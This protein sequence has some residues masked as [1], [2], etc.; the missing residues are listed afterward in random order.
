M[1]RKLFGILLSLCMILSL[2][3]VSAFAAGTGF[4][5]MPAEGTWS[6]EAIASAVQ[7]GLLQGD[8]GKLTPEGSLTR[9]QLAAIINR[10]FGAEEEADISGYTDVTASSWYYADIAKAVGMGTLQGYGGSMRP[11]DPVTRQEAFAVLARAFKLA[12]GSASSL[13]KFADSDQVADWAVPSLSAMVSAGYVQGSDGKLN[14][15]SS[16]SRAE[17]A[18][19]VY[20][21]ISVYLTSAAFLYGRIE[22]N[23]ISH[24]P[25][26]TLAGDRSRD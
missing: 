3:P 7:N 1:K 20:N 22:G 6:Y 17:F 10:A 9:S 4:S 13:T 23:A 19:V 14:P 24:A 26:V 12:D 18:Q 21:M 25:G 2:F 5:D 16:I 15:A 11:D 8:N